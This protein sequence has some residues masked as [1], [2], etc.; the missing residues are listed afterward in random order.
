[1]KNGRLILWPALATLV[2]LA[3]LLALGT[4][5]WLRRIEKEQILAAL[6]RSITETPAALDGPALAKLRVWPTGL[7]FETPGGMRELTR[8]TV[9]GAYLPARSVPIRATL[10]APKNAQSV[11]GIGF[12]WMTPLQVENG[13]IIFI[14]RGFVTANADYKAPPV[15]TPAGPQ[16]ITGLLRLTEKAQTFTPADNPAKGDY[17]IRDPK[18]MAKAVAISD[19]ADFF[20]DAERMGGDGLTPPV[21]IDAREMIGRIP[22]N[23]LQ[24][25]VTWYG[26]A[27]VLVVIFSVFARA[28]LQ[29]ANLREAGKQET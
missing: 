24:Y 12:F 22:N 18:V 15:E 9:R 23:H 6:E 21:G 2:A 16:I 14:N 27:L 4:W 13:P 17:F 7:R 28:R 26:F 25:A 3:I 20:I 10:P 11:G 8:V 19:A 1:M 29:E 5:Q